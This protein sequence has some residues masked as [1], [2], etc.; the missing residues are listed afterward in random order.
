MSFKGSAFQKI[1]TGLIIFNTVGL[2]GI[3]GGGFYAYKYVTSDNFEK[4]IKNKIMG[5]IQNVLPK[6][7]QSEIPDTTGIS[8][9]F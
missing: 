4:L 7:I 6:A 1:L 2:V 5:D 8:I 9:P 3:L